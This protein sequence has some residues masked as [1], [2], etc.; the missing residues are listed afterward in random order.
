MF[1]DKGVL[2]AVTM[3]SG[4][5]GFMLARGVVGASE[6]GRRESRDDCVGDARDGD[7]R[8]EDDEDEV[9]DE[10]ESESES[11]SEDEE[12]DSDG[13]ACFGLEGREERSREWP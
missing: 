13:A 7:V 1:F 11:E 4:A 3:A 12:S 9:E 10:E 5:E 8:E 2:A 6:A